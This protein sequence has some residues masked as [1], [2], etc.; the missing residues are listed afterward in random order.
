MKEGFITAL[1]TPLDEQGNLIPGSYRKQIDDQISS[2]AAGLLAMGTM[3][4]LG[5]IRGEAYERVVAT[6]AE[7]IHGRVP[8]LVG[9]SDN[10][11]ARVSDRLKIVD[12]YDADVVVITPPYYFQMDE[13]ALT[14]FFTKVAALTDK[15]IFL[16]DHPPITKHKITFPMVEKLARL[17]NIKGIKSGDLVLIRTIHD[18]RSI[19][20]DFLPIFSGSDLFCVAHAY[21]INRYLDGI[22]ACFPATIAAV[23]RYFDCGDS[24]GAKASLNTMMHARDRMI[25]MGI[26]PSFSC[27]MN[28]LGYE[29]NFAPDYES[30]LDDAGRRVVTGI[31]DGCGESLIG[32]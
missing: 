16:Y 13:A 21:G 26:W 29:G 15:D 14:G 19:K 6:A 1:G 11:L 7:A 12:R 24:E 25:A 18:S 17:P 28:L 10:S 3:G 22:F 32:Q 20:S 4:M 23:Q 27:A 9:V 5:C 2:G 8:L 30:A 31:L